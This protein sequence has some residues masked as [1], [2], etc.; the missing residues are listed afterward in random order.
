MPKSTIKSNRLISIVIPVYNEEA[1]INHLIGS[2][3]E[4]I[5]GYRYEILLIDDGSSDK[6]L[7]MLKKL[8]RKYKNVHFISFS[9]NFGHQAA[10]KAGL[11]N[12]KG[13]AVIMMDADNQHPPKL[14]PK[15]ISLWLEGYEVVNTVRDD[16]KT[17]FSKRITSS[18]FYWTINR[19]GNLALESGS[20]DFRLL[21]RKVVD[22]INSQKEA[23]LFLRAYVNWIGF[24]QTS[25]SYSPN[26]RF[27]G[28]SK[29]TFRKMFSFAANGLTQ[30]SIEPLRIAFS[31]ACVAFLIA[32][33]YSVYAIWVT[34]FTSEV[35]KG[36]ASL[37][38]LIVFLSGLQ[39]LLIG[40]LGEYVGRTFMQ[41]KN[42][43]EF[44]VRETDIK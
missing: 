16:S 24:R 19:V 4:F 25:L 39:F 40:L 7:E 32:I 12:A 1:V 2:I 15:L 21:D 35:V 3:L 27:A 13:D 20:A 30:F 22:V 31:L 6:S 34:L 28:E 9:R 33:V 42:R 26:K 37:V 44:I 43:P 18:L 38:V 41:T 36:W 17:R 11:L 23:H 5:D 10:L 29:Y 14:L 8:S